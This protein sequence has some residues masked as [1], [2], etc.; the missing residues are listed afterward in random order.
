MNCLIL[1]HR[2][3]HPLWFLSTGNP[4]YTRRTPM[5]D[6]RCNQLLLYVSYLEIK[7]LDKLSNIISFGRFC[8]WKFS[9]DLTLVV[10]V[11]S[12]ICL[13]LDSNEE[14]GRVTTVTSSRDNVFNKTERRRPATLYDR[15]DD[16]K[17]IRRWEVRHV[18]SHPY[19]LTLKKMNRC[20]VS[21]SCCRRCCRR[22]AARRRRASFDVSRDA[23][24]MSSWQARMMT[25]VLLT[26][27][28]TANAPQLTGAMSHHVF[29]IAFCVV[30]KYFI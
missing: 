21:F 3:S 5:L 28:V 16:C 27:F 23:A 7:T 4:G 6:H 30:Y 20:R 12:F 22:G 29:S 18:A 26:L 1:C 13:A 14:S 11:R 10:R 15:D 24:T 9:V 25:A 19:T 8:E 17:A 2:F